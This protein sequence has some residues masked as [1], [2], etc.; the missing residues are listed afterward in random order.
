MISKEQLEKFKDIWKKQFGGGIS[1]QKALEEATSLINFI[2]VVYK[3]MT[4]NEFE[5]VQ[6]RRK[7]IS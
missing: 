4:Q 1:D 3:P 7:E 5:A 2:K 6:R